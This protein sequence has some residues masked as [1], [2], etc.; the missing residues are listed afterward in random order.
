MPASP[1]WRRRGSC[2][3]D[4]GRG[5]RAR[6]WSSQ[7]SKAA[8][9]SS[10]FADR[11]QRDRTGTRSATRIGRRA[12]PPR[13]SCEWRRCRRRAAASSSGC[14]ASGCARPSRSLARLIT[15]E[16]GKIVAGEPG[17]S[18]GDDRH[19][20][21][22][23]RPVAAALRPHHRQRAARPSDDGAMAS[24]RSGAGDQR[25]QLPGRGLG[26]ECRAGAGV[27]QSG[28]LEAEREDAARAPKR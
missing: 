9:I 7:A 17:R 20:R 19:L 27:R 23:G 13:P 4:A 28:D 12:A 24:A 2:W 8:A 14:S 21:L 25:L 11:R 3:H 1:Q 16:S 10:A 15:L 18:A 26:V 6:S 22:R 5:S